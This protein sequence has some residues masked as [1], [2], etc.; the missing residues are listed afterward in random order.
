MKPYWGSR[1]VTEAKITCFSPRESKFS[2][3]PP[4]RVTHTPI[5]S[6]PEDM[7]PPGLCSPPHI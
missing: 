7:T 2:S 6:A 3:Q 5:T 4:C 1:Q